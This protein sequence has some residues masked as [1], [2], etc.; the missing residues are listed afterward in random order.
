MRHIECVWVAVCVGVG[1][2]KPRRV[3]YICSALFFPSLYLAPSS[4]LSLLLL[5]TIGQQFIVGTGIDTAF[6]VDATVALPP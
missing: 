4:S 5:S 2:S 1:V 3:W 6:I